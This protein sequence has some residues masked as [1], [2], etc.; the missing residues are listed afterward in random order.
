MATSRW[1][2]TLRGSGRRN[3]AAERG[4]W[5]RAL[6]VRHWSTCWPACRTDCQSEHPS[7]ISHPADRPSSFSAIFTP[8]SARY[9][10]ARIP[11]EHGDAWRRMRCLTVPCGAVRCNVVPHRFYLL[12]FLWTVVRADFFLPFCRPASY[13]LFCFI[14]CFCWQRNLIWFDLIWCERTFRLLIY[15]VHE[16]SHYK[17]NEKLKQHFKTKSTKAVTTLAE[18]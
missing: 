17:R 4:T 13:L 11:C 2:R 12:S 3:S 5:C 14:L 16:R 8:D 15:S 10:T 7:S 6:C 9:G 18:G 1:L